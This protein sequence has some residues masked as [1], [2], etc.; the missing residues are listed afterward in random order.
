MML[1]DNAENSI[2]GIE[3]RSET[4]IE[5]IEYKILETKMFINKCI[6]ME[7]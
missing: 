2:H 7:V 6:N 3:R 4:I 1:K 5:I